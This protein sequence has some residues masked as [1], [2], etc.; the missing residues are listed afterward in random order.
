MVFTY[1]ELADSST[2]FFVAELHQ[3]LLFEAGYPN[4]FVAQ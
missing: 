3:K 4:H 1:F 2:S